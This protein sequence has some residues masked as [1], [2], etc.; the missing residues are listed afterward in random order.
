MTPLFWPFWSDLALFEREFPS[1]VELSGQEL[2]MKKGRY[3]EEHFTALLV[4]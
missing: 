3:T 4:A 1:P 2:D